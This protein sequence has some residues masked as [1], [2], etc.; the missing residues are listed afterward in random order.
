MALARPDKPHGRLDLPGCTVTKQFG[1][2]RFGA[3]ERAVPEDVRLV[4]GGHGALGE[5][6]SFAG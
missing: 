2:L 3:Q 5:I 6:R 4:P 1:T